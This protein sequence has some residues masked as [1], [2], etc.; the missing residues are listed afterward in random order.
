MVFYVMCIHEAIPVDYVFNPQ[1][2]LSSY[3]RTL[4]VRVHIAMWYTYE[5]KHFQNIVVFSPY[6]PCKRM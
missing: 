6:H 3:H 2:L 1:Q 4:S 5:I